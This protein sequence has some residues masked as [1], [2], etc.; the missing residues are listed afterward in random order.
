MAIVLEDS[1]VLYP[2]KQSWE[3]IYLFILHTL[4]GKKYRNHQSVGVFFISIFF[5]KV[6]QL[7]FF[8]IFKPEA[9]PW[10]QHVMTGTEHP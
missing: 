9:L 1:V 3:F 4:H 5:F 2:S 6:T 7:N 8:S 10:T